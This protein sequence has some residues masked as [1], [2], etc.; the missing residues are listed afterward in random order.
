MNQLWC[1]PRVP[2]R[3]ADKQ[4]VESATNINGVQI[5]G[6]SSSQQ[7][8]DEGLRIATAFPMETRREPKDASTTLVRRGEDAATLR[9]MVEF[10][11]TIE[12]R[13]LEKL[14]RDLP[15]LSTLSEK[16]TE[17]AFRVIERRLRN[18][19]PADRLKLRIAAREIASD[20]EASMALM[21]DVFHDLDEPLPSS[22]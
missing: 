21:H 7:S 5:C 13:P 6:G 14:L 16:K 8:P 19:S 18:L 9:E 3:R 17:L 2:L 20:S 4:G 1:E 15:G 11:D 10:A 22:D 12:A